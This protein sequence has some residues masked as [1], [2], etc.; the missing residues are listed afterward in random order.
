MVGA[1]LLV[2]V[3]LYGGFGF[4]LVCSFGV[5]VVYCCSCVDLGVWFVVALTVRAVVLWVL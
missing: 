3:V 5:L 2:F 1:G 4:G